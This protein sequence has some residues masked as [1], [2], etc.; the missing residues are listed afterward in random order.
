[1]ARFRYS[2]YSARNPEDSREGMF[3]EAG[4]KDEAIAIISAQGYVLTSVEEVND[5]G[6][7]INLSFKR[8]VKD[9]DIAFVTRQMATMVQA[10]MSPIETLEV[11][12]KVSTNK[13]LA[14]ALDDVR[15]AIQQGAAPSEAFKQHPD[16]FDDS[17]TSLVAAGEESGELAESLSRL[18]DA[19][20][21]RAQFRREV[22]SAM[23][24]PLSVIVFALGIV[25]AMLMFVVPAFE[26]IFAEVKGELPAM[27][28]AL[29]AASDI[30]TNQWYLILIV[31]PA[32]VYAIRRWIKT[33]GG[34]R[35]WD[36]YKINQKPKKLADLYEKIITARF[37]RSLA[38]L[39]GA[40]IPV[41]RALEISGPTAN[42]ILIQEQIQDASEDIQQGATIAQALSDNEVLPDMAAAMLIAGER[43]GEVSVMMDKVAEVYEAEVEA[44]VK[45][46]KSII[47]PALMVLIGGIVGL[48]VVSL[49]MP[50]FSIY[51]QIG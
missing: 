37:M 42:N 31:P 47:E 36:R 28:K 33:D 22:K 41:L 5:G 26:E 14:A 6:L 11:L 32:L 18:A 38:T 20:D 40:G 19:L 12:V 23:V 44:T 48:V 50:L 2:A 27:T 34:K 21:K 1:M 8:R 49:Y 16:I 13:R 45:T 43:S 7:D 4:S 46:I 30:V 3:I 9:Q 35:I 24:Y 15:E 29:V 39:Y 17:Y 51:D 25:T 10:G